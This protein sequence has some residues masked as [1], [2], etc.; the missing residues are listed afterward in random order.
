ME[1]VLSKL[2]N[3]QM[4]ELCDKI[5]KRNVKYL[6]YT[7]LALILTCDDETCECKEATLGEVIDQLMQCSLVKK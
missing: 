1:N 7:Y 3:G 5:E 2:G 4:L 6:M